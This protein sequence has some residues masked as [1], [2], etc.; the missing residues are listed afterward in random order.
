VK[1]INHQSVICNHQSKR[2]SAATS[3]PV[4]LFQSAIL[5]CVS[6]DTSLA[7]SQG[8]SVWFPNLYLAFKEN[9]PEYEQ[10]SFARDVSWLHFLNCFFHA[11]DVKPSTAS[12]LAAPAGSNNDVELAWSRS[13][14][15]AP[16]SYQVLQ[17]TNPASIFADPATSLDLWTASG[18]SLAN[19]EG[20]SAFY[21]GVGNN[22]DSRLTLNAP[23]TLSGP[24]CLSFAAHVNTYEAQDTAGNV[25]H[26]VCYVEI[27]SDTSHWTIL[28]SLYGPGDTWVDCRYVIDGMQKTE[29][30]RQEQILHSAFC[31][32]HS[33]FIRFRFRTGPA[34][35]IDGVYIDSIEVQGYDSLRTVAA[36]RQ[37]TAMSLHDERHGAHWY[38]VVPTDSFGNVGYVSN[39]AQ[40]GLESYAEPYSIPAPIILGRTPKDIVLVCDY[41]AGE[42]PDVSILTLSGELVKTFSKVSGRLI[43][44]QGE[45][46]SNHL[47]AS[48]IY[49]VAVKGS[50]FK[51]IGRIAVVR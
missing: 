16:V 4:D 23:F 44:W 34:S 40:I 28:D 10:L 22:L 36:D 3:S 45:N 11:D 2:P 35:H 47:V 41:P 26:D 15:L 50:G 49:F 9:Y 51:T 37:D 43:H 27:A 30:K 39:L 24:G 7:K 5:A 33:A 1:P 38:A 19:Y 25:T 13:S 12:V 18:F 42:T 14:D 6:N 48:G 20:R 32:L 17:A 8:I 29:G 21:S 31:T 46:E